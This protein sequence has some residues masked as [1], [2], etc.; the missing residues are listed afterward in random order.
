MQN[1][2]KNSSNSGFMS[3]LGS[4]GSAFLGNTKIFS[5]EDMKE[6]R[7]KSDGESILVAFRDMPIDNYR[8]KDGPR[9]MFGLPEHRTGP[10]AQDYAEKFPEGSDGHMI[11][12]GDFVGKLASAVKAL[13]A[14]TRK[15]A[16]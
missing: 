3:A 1:A 5:D 6:D 13:D 2:A 7:H 14:R 15:R 16:A 4:I 10:M 9:K 8:Y 12:L 11:D